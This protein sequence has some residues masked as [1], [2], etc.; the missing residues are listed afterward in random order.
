MCPVHIDGVTLLLSF[1]NGKERRMKRRM[2]WIGTESEDS[3]NL[4]VLERDEEEY[5]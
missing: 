3:S 4:G 2:E 5:S 1:T